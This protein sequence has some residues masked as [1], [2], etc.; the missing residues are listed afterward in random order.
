MEFALRNQFCLWRIF[1]NL[2]FISHFQLYRVG[3]KTNNK[4]VK[5]PRQSFVYFLNPDADTEVF[6]LIPILNEKLAYLKRFNNKSVNAYDYF[7]Q[8][9]D[10]AY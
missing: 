3:I 6:P 7:Q 2:N 10:L 5:E 1:C 8:R 4:I 9:A